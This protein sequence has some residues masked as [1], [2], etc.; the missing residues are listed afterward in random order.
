M[1][2]RTCQTS[3]K[4]TVLKKKAFTDIFIKRP[5]LSIVVSLFILVMG[6]RSI[7]ALPIQQFPSVESAI[8][9]VQT[10][11][12][13]ADPETIASFITTPLENAIAQVNGI[14]YI[15]S[16]STQNTSMILANLI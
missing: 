3:N 8:I 10:T 2:I 13:G 7:G 16:S 12:Q 9:Q 4:E 14:D 15:T 11:F 6:L 1:L 5:V